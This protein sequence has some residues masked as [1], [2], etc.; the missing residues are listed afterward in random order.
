MVACCYLAV[1]W[2]R[3]IVMLLPACFCVMVVASA[4]VAEYS[5][6]IHLS[7]GLVLHIGRHVGPFLK[8]VGF[9]GLL[10]CSPL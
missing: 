6:C 10:V 4:V 1:G 9:D 8:S 2:A 5:F 7:C 3:C